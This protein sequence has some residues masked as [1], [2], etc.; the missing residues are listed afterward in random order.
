VL[1]V[2]VWE[3]ALVFDLVPPSL[4]AAP[5]DVRVALELEEA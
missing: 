5:T 4:T 1:V 3:P 2:V